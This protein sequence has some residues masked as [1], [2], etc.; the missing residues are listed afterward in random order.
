MPGLGGQLNEGEGSNARFQNVVFCAKKIIQKLHLCIVREERTNK[1][2]VNPN[3]IGE[4][5]IC[6]LFYYSK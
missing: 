5:Q 6:P 4:V 2:I 3:C 1:L